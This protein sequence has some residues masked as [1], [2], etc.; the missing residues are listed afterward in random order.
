MELSVQIYSLIMSFV[1][2]C[3]FYVELLYFYKLYFKVISLLKFFL[4]MLFVLINATVYFF[5]LYLI[6]NGVLHLYFF[7][8]MLLGYY[9]FSKIFTLLFTLFRK[10]E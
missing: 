1:F 9:I 4:S 8:S 2:G 5:L 10:K 6:N 7:I 3:L